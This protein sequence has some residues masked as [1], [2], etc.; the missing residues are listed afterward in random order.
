MP[1]CSAFMEAAPT[2]YSK[3]C[4]PDKPISHWFWNRAS[5][6]NSHNGS[7]CDVYMEVREQLKSCNVKPVNHYHVKSRTRAALLQWNLSHVCEGP[8]PGANAGSST[9]WVGGSLI[10][11]AME[12]ILISQ[13]KLGLVG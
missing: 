2:L 3:T 5:N 9:E 6:N 13:A 8:A 10:S 7:D 4:T 12:H 1:L 11:M